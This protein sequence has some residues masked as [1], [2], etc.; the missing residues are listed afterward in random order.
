VPLLDGALD[1]GKAASLPQPT[2]QWLPG[3]QELQQALLGLR[4]RGPAPAQQQQQQQQHQPSV[5]VG[6][7]DAGRQAAPDK[8]M[9]HN[10]V[11]LARLAAIVCDLAASG[12]APVPIALPEGATVQLLV[13]LL[14]L[15]LDYRAEAVA[16]SALAEAVAAVAHAADKHSWPGIAS[17]VAAR[18]AA[19]LGP[20]HR[21]AAL[22]LARLEGRGQ[23]VRQ[24]RQVAALRLLGNMLGAQSG[25]DDYQVGQ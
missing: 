7:S 14:H 23:R 19:P 17:A 3:A 22:L 2:I 1:L 5:G 18:V 21:S 25:A 13:E 24:L 10:L 4:S 6:A 15:Q 16:R 12:R 20:S 8:L 11:L 9:L